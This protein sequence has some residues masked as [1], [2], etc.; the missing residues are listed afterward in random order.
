MDP[1]FAIARHRLGICYERKGMY[2]AAISEFQKV[3]SLG[4]KWVAVGDLGQVYAKIGNRSEAQKALAELQQQSKQHYVSPASVAFIYAALGDRDRAF[5][6]LD[7]SVEEHDL[8]TVRLK[9]DQR[10]DSLR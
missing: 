1:A 2:D 10:F 6:W 7:K 9:V 3:T 4:A 5:A 8:T